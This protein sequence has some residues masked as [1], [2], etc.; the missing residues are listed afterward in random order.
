MSAI[1]ESINLNRQDIY[2]SVS[3]N[4]NPSFNTINK[5]ITACGRKS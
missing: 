4:G 5:V 3:E 2:K 1:A